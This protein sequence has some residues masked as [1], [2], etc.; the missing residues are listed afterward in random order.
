MRAVIYSP[1]LSL[2]AILLVG[3]TLFYVFAATFLWAVTYRREARE[4]AQALDEHGVIAPG[5]VVDRWDETYS[6]E[7]SNV[8]MFYLTYRYG[9]CVLKQRVSEETYNKTVLGS[10]VRVRC[11]SNTP[12]IARLEDA[13]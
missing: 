10:D 11:L 9:S 8:T 2:L 7:N 4:H 3:A 13:H 5:V 6:T 1:L 12:M